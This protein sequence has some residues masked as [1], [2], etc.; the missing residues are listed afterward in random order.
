MP[1]FFL[2]VCTWIVT[3]ELPRRV[4]RSDAQFL[5][6]CSFLTKRFRPGMEIASVFFLIRA[7]D[8]HGRRRQVEWPAVPR[9]IV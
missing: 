5:S 9:N 4:A 1:I 6:S 3:V 7:S 8:E 2:A